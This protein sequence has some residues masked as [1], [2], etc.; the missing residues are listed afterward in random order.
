MNTVS[1]VPIPVGL[2]Q[3]GCGGKTAV[4]VSNRQERGY[5]K[6]V[7]VRFVP[8]HNAWA[9]GRFSLIQPPNPSGLCLCGCGES[10]SLAAT[11]CRR[12]GNIKGLPQRFVNGHGSRR[13][14]FPP[15]KTLSE[16]LWQ[17]VIKSD[18]CWEWQG[19][20]TEGYGNFTYQ[21]K[22]YHCHRVSW[23]LAYGP[24]PGGLW[25][26]HRCDNRK[27]VRPDHLFLGT[28][29]DNIQD[30]VAKGRHSFHRRADRPCGQ[31]HPNA[32]LTDHAVR[33]IRAYAPTTSIAALARRHGVSESAIQAVLHGDTW[34]HVT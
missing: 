20:L 10:T 14:I 13:R 30:M 28:H 15:K 8:G 25:V 9:D 5:I 22:N 32:K 34:I 26:L 18:S 17:R 33:D 27:C 11:T 1:E 6:G 21:R 2:C 3:C 7:P 29:L 4:A 12:L 16:T 23:E 19:A 31:A 24:I